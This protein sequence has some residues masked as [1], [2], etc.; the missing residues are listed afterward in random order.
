M[1]AV[2]A[3]AA[4]AITCAGCAVAPVPLTDEELS[5]ATASAAR[6]ATADQE[7]ITASIDLY[8]AMARALK[9]NLDQRVELAEMSL[10]S[11]EL[12]LAHFSFLPNMVANSGYVARNRQLASSSQSIDSGQQSLEPSTSTDRRL[13]TSDLSF[14]WNV[15]DFGL[16]YVRARQAAD[17]VLVQR[18]IRRKIVHRII[19][20]VR[21]AYWRAV[22][23]ER[24]ME[25]LSQ[26]ER[27]AESALGEARALYESRRT[28]PITALTYERELVEIKRAIAELQRELNSA[29]AQVAVLINVRPGTRFSLVRAHQGGGGLAIGKPYREMV[30]VALNNRPEMREILYRGRINE[31]E[32]DAALLELLPGLQAFAGSNYDSNSFLEHNQW[33]NWGA[34]ASWHLLKVFSYPARREVVELQGGLIKSRALALSMAIMMQ[35]HVSRVRFLHAGKELKIA[36]EYSG[37]Q[38]R[39]VEHIRTEASAERVSRQTLIREEMNTLIADAKQD[40]AFASLQNAFANVFASMGLDPYVDEADT[41]LDIKS[42][43]RQLRQIWFERGDMNAAPGRL[44]LTH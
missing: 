21:T 27:E 12:D 18:E 4:T 42:L 32:A 17:K 29:K 35:V 36:T 28:S 23:A 25:R 7:P 13:R 37:V 5:L 41:G 9:Y 1:R 33:V 19:E 34:K 26:L 22:S 24:L 31:H 38:K 30:E 15:L 43:A 8:E 2:A 40:I 14:S 11:A 3:L 16:S 10:R 44:R 6:Q 20:D 39:L